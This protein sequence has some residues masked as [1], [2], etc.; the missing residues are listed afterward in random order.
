MRS[1]SALDATHLDGLVVTR[2]WELQLVFEGRLTQLLAEVGLTAA[3]FRLVGEL[4]RAPEGM[5]QR[6]LAER[7]GVKASTVSVAITKLVA[8]GVV[9]RVED[10]DDTRAWRIRL[11]SRAPL[12]PG[13][14][15]F[16]TLEAE[17]VGELSA[18]DR[19]TLAALLDRVTNHL[20]QPRSTR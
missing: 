2:L 8:D 11:A 1:R 16:E 15:L 14:K 10:P 13:I 7:L 5:S 18:R 17:A 6:V 20:S 3:G 12:G 19:K 9:E 4:M